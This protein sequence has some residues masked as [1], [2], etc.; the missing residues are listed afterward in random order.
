[1][2]PHRNTLIDFGS[3]E[4]IET[5]GVSWA[6]LE[7]AAVRAGLWDALFCCPAAHAPRAPAPHLPA[8]LKSTAPKRAFID[9]RPNALITDRLPTP[10]WLLFCASFYTYRVLRC[11]L[12]L[13]THADWLERRS[14]L[15]PALEQLAAL[16][17]CGQLTPALD[18]VY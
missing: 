16:V 18:K 5:E 4:L 10:L 8:V 17:D 7:A 9:L 12:G 3:A 14:Q 15:T 13:G 1:P 6:A 2:A 11:I